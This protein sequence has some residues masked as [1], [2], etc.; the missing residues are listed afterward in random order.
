[1]KRRFL[2]LAALAATVALPA[3]AAERHPLAR[4]AERTFFTALNTDVTRRDAALV[5]LATAHAVDPTDARTCLLVGL[6][7]LWS[8]AEAGPRDPKAIEHVV[9]AE[10]YLARAQELDPSDDRIPSWLVPARV[11]VASIERAPE[12]IAA[13]IASL[14]E[15]YAKRPAFHSFTLA[16]LAGQAGPGS[17]RFERGRAA[18]RE[19]LGK[20]CD[21]TR[22]RACG[23]APR[24]PHNT[25]GF[26]LFAAEYEARGGDR[27]AARALLARLRTGDGYASW[28]YRAEA[29]ELLASLDAP[30]ST[31]RTSSFSPQKGISCRLC[32]GGK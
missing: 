32:H 19:V 31:P 1:M 13:A 24:W 2:P 12:R 23:N 27:E 28:P 18:L 4:D 30:A 6:S 15:A 29:E 16:F 21:V 25:E 7:H 5:E 3:L 8:A 20:P 14:E 11:S 10:H 9:L 22:D 17:P 26:Q